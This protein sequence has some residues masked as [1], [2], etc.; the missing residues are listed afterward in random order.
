MRAAICAAM[1]CLLAITAL[2]SADVA[3]STNTTAQQFSALTVEEK[4]SYLDGVM[5][6][7]AIEHA[8]NGRDWVCPKDQSMTVYLLLTEKAIST[9]SATEGPSALRKPA[10]FYALVA[11][12]AMGCQAQPRGPKKGK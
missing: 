10:A 6:T 4:L 3:V 5:D 11:Q 1:F 2:A 8:V 7:L 12:E 9:Y